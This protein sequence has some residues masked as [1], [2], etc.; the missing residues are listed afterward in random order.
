MLGQTV[1]KI[2]SGGEIIDI[3]NLSA[4]APSITLPQG[5]EVGRNLSVH[6]RA[7]GAKDGPA[8]TALIRDCPPLD[9]NSAYCNLLQCSHF[10]DTCVMAERDGKLI[11][12]VSGYRPPSTPDQFFIWQVAV[13]EDARGA[14]LGGLM[15]DALL[16]RPSARGARVLATT[17]TKANVAS[18]ALFTA[19]ARKRNL[20]LTKAP[21]F[22]RDDHF[23][24]AHDTEWQVT[25]GPL[26]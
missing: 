23:A 13:H 19:F 10:A 24:G 1:Q 17:I 21:M 12:W 26:S 6:L 20:M 7:P 15:L 25:I 18:W 14:G 11:G 5:G 8:V 4:S 2:P 16:R 22:L 9:A 3:A